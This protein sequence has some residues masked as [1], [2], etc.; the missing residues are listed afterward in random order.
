MLKFGAGQPGMDVFAANARRTADFAQHGA[1]LPSLAVA[2][3][4]YA[5]AFAAALRADRIAQIGRALDVLS[6][7]R[8]DD[9]AHCNA[10]FLGC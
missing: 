3:D 6:I 8:D 2:N 10:R 9:V 7:H 1:E 4:V 5:D